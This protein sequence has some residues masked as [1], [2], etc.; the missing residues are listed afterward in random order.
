MSAADQ[1]LA[2][3]RA[4]ECA[5]DR[6]EPFRAGGRRNSW[7]GGWRHV[8]F[9]VEHRPRWYRRRPWFVLMDYSGHGFSDRDV[10]CS[11]HR[12]MAEANAEAARMW[13]DIEADH[14]R[15]EAHQAARAESEATR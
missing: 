9:E 5:A 7:G 3:H 14:E 8:R 13:A 10:V 1:G 11:R 6:S 12:T 4:T 2:V 15:T